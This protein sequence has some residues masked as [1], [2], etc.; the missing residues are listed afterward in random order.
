MIP[1]FQPFFEPFTEAPPECNKDPR[2]EGIECRADLGRALFVC[3]RE[4]WGLHTELARAESCWHYALVGVVIGCL[5]ATIVNFAFFILCLACRKACTPSPRGRTTQGTQT[6]PRQG[7]HREVQ[8]SVEV[9]SISCSAAS[10]EEAGRTEDT[11]ASTWVDGHGFV[12]KKRTR[13]RQS[14]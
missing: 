7:T 10:P 1:D 13:V 4:F 14:P 9:R 3:W 8:A 2:L 11:T 12:H 5:L 6:S